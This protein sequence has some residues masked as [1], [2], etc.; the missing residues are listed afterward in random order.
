VDFQGI[1][2]GSYTYGVT[3][4]DVSAGNTP[5]C[6]VRIAEDFSSWVVSQVQ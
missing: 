1:K 6:V 3:L 5:I 2:D 4:L